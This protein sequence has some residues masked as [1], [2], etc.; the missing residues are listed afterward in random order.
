MSETAYLFIHVSRIGDSLFATPAMRAL[1]AH[2]PGAVIDIL[3]HPKRCAVFEGLPFIRRVG[4]VT[5][6]TAWLRGRLGTK[7]YDWAIVYGYDRPLLSLGLRVARRCVAFRQPD[8]AINQRLTTLVE[9]P[10]YQSEHAI[11]QLS[12][13]PEALG[14]TTRSERIAFVT[15]PAERAH[16]AA[17]L[18]AFL[19]ASPLIGI[20]P[21]SFP[22]KPYR[23]WPMAHFIGL[24]QRILDQ[25]PQARFV[26]FGGPDDRHRTAPL[27]DALGDRAMNLAGVLTLRQS[28]AVMPHLDLYL[29]VDTGLTHMMSALDTP[30]VLFY[31]CISPPELTGPLQHPACHFLTLDP[32]GRPCNEAIG[33]GEITIDQALVAITRILAPFTGSAPRLRNEKRA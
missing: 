30:M 10:A 27:T 4:G 26:I 9:P 29:G 17:R 13:L 32:R 31:H 18:G 24:C 19:D 6:A 33:L 15:T 28:G 5:P 7:P 3:G 14:V 11:H 12:R 16:S 1:A 22:T 2:D 25:W 23:D 21:C 8:P 20:Q